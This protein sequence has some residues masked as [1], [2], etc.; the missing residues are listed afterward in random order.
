MGYIYSIAVLIIFPLIMVM[1]YR[2]LDKVNNYK[3][4]RAKLLGLGGSI[5]ISLLVTTIISLISLLLIFNLF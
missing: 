4:K 1:A 5:S 3:T 2:Y